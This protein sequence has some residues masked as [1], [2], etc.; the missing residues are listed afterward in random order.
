MANERVLALAP[1]LTRRAP[2]SARSPVGR[3]GAIAARALDKCRAEIAGRAGPYQYNCPLDREFFKFTKIDAAEFKTFVG[4]GASDDEV[5]DWVASK[6]RVRDS[7]QIS[8]WNLW[9]RVNPINLL[10]DFDDW[11]YV[12]RCGSMVQRRDEQK[13]NKLKLRT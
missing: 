6:S 3:Y 1:D 12:R 2:R 8:L 4:T 13:A 7:K 9:F 10:L 5:A 11:L